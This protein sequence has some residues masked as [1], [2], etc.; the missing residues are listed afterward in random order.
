L[1]LFFRSL[2]K[3]PGG[4]WHAGPVNHT[5]VRCRKAAAWIAGISPAK[6][7][8]SSPRTVTIGHGSPPNS[9]G[10]H[11]EAAPL[12]LPNRRR[13]R[14]ELPSRQPPGSTFRKRL[15]GNAQGRRSGSMLDQGLEIR[16][17]NGSECVPFGRTNLMPVL[18]KIASR[19]HQILWDF[20]GGLPHMGIG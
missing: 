5:A 16:S 7:A 4:A 10:M 17:P 2:R 3:G 18:S 6:A 13:S 15:S 14:A 8:H 20:S 1:V 12:A 19:I 9:C 11:A